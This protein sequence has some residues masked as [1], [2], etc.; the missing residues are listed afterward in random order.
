M[1]KSL[2]I[3]L[4][5]LPSSLHHLH[6][7]HILYHLVLL[8]F[9]NDYLFFCQVQTAH[10]LRMNDFILENCMF[11][12]FEVEYHINRHKSITASAS[13]ELRFIFWARKYLSTF[14]PLHVS[15][16]RPNLNYAIPF[17][18]CSVVE[19]SR[20][21]T[22]FL[23]TGLHYLRIVPWPLLAESVIFNSTSGSIQNTNN[24]IRNPVWVALN[25]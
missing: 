13:K 15:Q 24:T 1:F 8:N 16:I 6:M 4:T 22:V 21:E 19:G 10:P 12:S 7:P 9:C 17:F 20:K 3:S 5:V 2:L 11:F 23:L 25:H 18:R 14:N